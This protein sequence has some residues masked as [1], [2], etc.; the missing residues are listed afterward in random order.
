MSEWCNTGN[1]EC[2]RSST[3]LVTLEAAANPKWLV[4]PDT[5]G[6]I[7]TFEESGG[8]VATTSGTH[9]FSPT[10]EL[11][12][13]SSVSAFRD[14]SANIVGEPTSYTFN[15]AINTELA[16]GGR[17][18]IK[19]PSGATVPSSLAVTIGGVTASH[20]ANTHS[21][22]SYLSEILLTQACSTTCT[23]GQA[24]VVVVSGILNPGSTKP[25]TNSFT[26]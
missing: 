7:I 17:I 12:P 10:I 1:S 19:F 4:S 14:S 23:S 11:T 5:T 18:R 2:T 6:T 3:F 25:I 24:F 8:L 22:T 21:G 20:T 13:F 15:F 9:R 26:V 16:A